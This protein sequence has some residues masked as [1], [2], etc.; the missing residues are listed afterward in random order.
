M[1]AEKA[2]DLC[3]QLADQ[4]SAWR[5]TL[6]ALIIPALKALPP[7]QEVENDFFAGKPVPQFQHVADML[8]A[9]VDWL[10][11][12]MDANEWVIE[13]NK[14]EGMTEESALTCQVRTWIG[15]QVLPQKE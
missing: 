10:S 15:Y 2:A 6:I 12:V 1:H 4:C 13:Q 14:R 5:S 3:Q 8:N 11:V 7:T 9:K